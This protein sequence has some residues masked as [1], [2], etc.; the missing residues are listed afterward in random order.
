M[1][2]AGDFV[3][4]LPGTAG[5]TSCLTQQVSLWSPP[6]YLYSVGGAG[7]PLN[8]GNR[9]YLPNLPSSRVVDSKGKGSPLGSIGLEAICPHGYCPSAREAQSP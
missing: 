7:V 6:V 9:R 3:M 8:V 5:A 1:T 4:N 2:R